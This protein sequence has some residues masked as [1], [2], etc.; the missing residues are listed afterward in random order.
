MEGCI[1]LLSLDQI[2]STFG[3]SDDLGACNQCPNLVYKD[4]MVT[5]KLIDGGV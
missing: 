2:K 4:G 5:C 1:K 3:T